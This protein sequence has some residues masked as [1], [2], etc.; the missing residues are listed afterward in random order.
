MARMTLAIE[1]V[2]AEHDI[3]A[4]TNDRIEAARTGGNDAKAKDLENDRRER[5]IR[6]DNPFEFMVD[7]TDELC[8]PLYIKLRAI[9][10]SEPQNLAAVVAAN[11]QVAA[12]VPQKLDDRRPPHA[13][14][15]LATP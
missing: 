6:R 9:A 15:R 5:E 7:T 13:R 4:R 10:K 1:G 2:L 3:I 8:A 12:A 11:V 14:V